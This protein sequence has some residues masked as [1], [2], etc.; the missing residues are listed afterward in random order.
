MKKIYI[1]SSLIVL[2]CLASCSD[3]L[4][5]DKLT[6]T[7]LTYDD[8]FKSPHGAAGF[9]N[10]AYNT[11]PDGFNQVGSALFASASDEAVHSESSSLIHLFTS[12]S[13]STSNNPDDVWTAMYEGIRKCNIFLKELDPDSG[14]IVKYNSIDEEDR[15]NYR[16]QALFLR[17][18]FHFE[19][20]KRYQNIFY[21]RKVLDPNNEDEVFGIK[22]CDFQEATDSIVQDCDSAILYLPTEITEDENLGRPSKA[23]PM[24]LKSRVL[25]YAASPLNNPSGDVTLWQKAEDAAAELYDQRSALGLGLMSKSDYASIFTTPYNKEVIFATKAY[26]RNDIESNNFP[27]SFQGK[28]YTNPTQNLVDAYAMSGTSYGDPMKNYDPEHP[29]TGR[30]MRFA[31]TILYNGASFKDATL[32]TYEGATDG[33]YATSTATKTGYYM[34]KFISPDISLQKGETATKSWVIFRFAEII[35]N[36]AEAR[37]EVLDDPKDKTL[38]DLLNLIRN[39]AGLR[40]FRNTSE[41]ITDKDEMREYIKKE[42]QVELALEGHR[43]WDLRRWKD[44]DILENSAMGMKI[45]QVDSLDTNGNLVYDTEGNPVYKYTYTSF[46]AEERQFD[47]KLYWYPIPRTEILKYKSVGIDITQNPGW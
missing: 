19:L 29:Y 30:E 15:D 4:D 26:S 1:F 21:V 23:A 27:I 38:H 46:T 2:F 39:R 33:L 6:D 3:Y 36:Y 34:K 41:Y 18:Y 45:E 5:R 17:A 8:I 37:N 31:A 40:P 11:I 16:G 24:A 13:I 42:R 25:L 10:N 44:L 14:L 22:Q 12:N 9:L 32:Y 20:L 47:P 7:T 28:G 35:L 43:Y